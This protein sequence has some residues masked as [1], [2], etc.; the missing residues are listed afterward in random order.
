MSARHSHRHIRFSLPQIVSWDSFEAVLETLA[1]ETGE[2]TV[3]LD[4]SR[5][6]HLHYAAMTR[7]A[8]RLHQ[9]SRSI[10][11]IALSGLDPYV[12]QIVEFALSG[13][14]WDLFFLEAMEETEASH[15]GGN[16]ISRLSFLPGEQAIDTDSS[17]FLGLWTPC[18]N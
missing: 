8:G 18:P 17:P 12:R 9:L 16:R 3:E 11:P 1:K 14:D 5:C 4:F 7:F 13:R 6:L 10:Q 15:P 2:E